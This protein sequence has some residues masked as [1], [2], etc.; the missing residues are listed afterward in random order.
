MTAATPA[1]RGHLKQQ[2]AALHS[3]V[4]PIHEFE[5]GVEALGASLKSTGLDPQ[6]IRTML[7]SGDGGVSKLHADDVAHQ[8]EEFAEN[9]QHQLARLVLE[10]LQAHSAAIASTL[11]QARAFDEESDAHDA[12]KLR[13]LALSK[14]TP[15]ET[16]SYAMQEL[17]DR[18]TTLALQLFDT[19][20]SLAD[21]CGAQRFLPQKT[22]GELMVAQM[23]YHQ[24]CARLLEAAMP[25]VSE[26][27]REAEARRIA[28]EEEQAAAAE[29]RKAMPQPT[30]RAQGSTL[31]E[32]YLH[33]GT[34]GFSA[35]TDAVKEHLNRLKPWSR[36][37]FV[38]TQDGK[39]CTPPPG[40]E[41]RAVQLRA[42]SAAHALGPRNTHTDY[43]KSPEEARSP[44][45]PLDINLLE[46]VSPVGGGLEFELRFPRVGGYH[47]RR[48]SRSA[49]VRSS[50]ARRRRARPDVCLVTRLSYR[51]R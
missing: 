28:L 27:L 19:Q 42:A 36:R 17:S 46:A 15:L 25:E 43:Y 26:V 7:S 5:A 2:C 48:V 14:D 34:F 22:L 18:S 47:C 31:L 9:L 12:A 11:K 10:P 45:V 29:A 50:V 21:V 35:Q 38:L 20:R 24:S 39:L 40:L 37:W 16:R 3:Y 41:P 33:K 6:H 49:A 30:V 8:L 44:K 4:G 23:S 32:G 1:Q 13:Y 51:W